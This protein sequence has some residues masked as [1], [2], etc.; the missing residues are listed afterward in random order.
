MPLCIFEGMAKTPT[1][2]PRALK[3]RSGWYVLLTWPGAQEEQV[4]DFA[5]EADAQAWIDNEAK[6]WLAKRQTQRPTD[7][8]Q[9]AKR[10][11]D[12]AT[13]D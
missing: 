4:N 5:T 2:Q 3:D 11:V 9:L 13:D 8:N 7:A 6:A 1:L 10:I 12:I